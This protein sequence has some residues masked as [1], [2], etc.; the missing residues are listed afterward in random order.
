MSLI[1]LVELVRAMEL[2]NRVSPGFSAP[3][4]GSFPRR[5]RNFRAR[6]WVTLGDRGT[7][8]TFLE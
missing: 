7:R 6:R 4:G 5:A 1:V 3:L 2:P 8:T